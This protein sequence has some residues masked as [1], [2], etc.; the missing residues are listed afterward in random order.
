MQFAQNLANVP[1]HGSLW[2]RVAALCL[3]K[4]NADGKC[5]SEAPLCKGSTYSAFRPFRAKPLPSKRGEGP[6]IASEPGSFDE[7][8][9]HRST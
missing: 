2:P 8:S 9:V 3:G 4:E 7:G 1:D 5:F 6:Q